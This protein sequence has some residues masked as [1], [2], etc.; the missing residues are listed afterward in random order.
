[1]KNGLPLLGGEGR[2]EGERFRLLKSSGRQSVEK[3]H[4]APRVGT[5][6]TRFP[7]EIAGFVPGAP[8]GRIFQKALKK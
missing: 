4:T 7:L 8:T 1:M 2:G 3:L 6:P 5:R